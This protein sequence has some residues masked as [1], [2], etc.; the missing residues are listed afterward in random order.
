MIISFI[1]QKGG[2]GKTTSAIN[3]GAY[4]ASMGQKILLLDLDPQ[5]NAT[6]GMGGDPRS[7]ESLYQVLIQGQNIK[8][9][10]K[11]SRIKGLDIIPGSNDLSGASI[12]LVDAQNREFKLQTVLKELNEEGFY[13]FIFID[14]PPS[15]GILT[16]NGLVA[17]NQLIIP[18]QCEYFAL[19]GLGQLLNTID[20]VRKGLK[21]D[22]FVLGAFLT[23]HDR[24]NSL[25]W[26][27]IKEVQKNFPYYVF[28]TIIPRNVS[29][30]EAP[31]FGKSIL[32]YDRH[33]Q[34]ARSYEALAREFIDVA[35]K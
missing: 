18:V 30:A 9:V 15:L 19:E 13:D 24:R 25:S 32:E 8:D 10:I 16:I 33:S 1:N 35:V 11:K 6:S 29:L 27:V 28:E 34:G 31:S 5:A 22:L 4:L 14:C 17:S 23:M 20:L 7:T 21:S 2:S 26:E 12:E 3:L